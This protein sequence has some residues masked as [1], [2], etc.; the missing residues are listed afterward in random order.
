MAKRTLPTLRILV[1]APILCAWLIACQGQPAE[2]GP[3]P[4][5]PESETPPIE[6][7]PPEPVLGPAALGETCG[8][9]AGIACQDA[10]WCDPEPGL[11]GG[12]DIAGTCI[13]VPDFCT[14]DYRPVCGCDKKTYSNDC[15]RQAARVAKDHDGECT[16]TEAPAT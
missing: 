2:K 10:L 14:K 16:D 12:A 9:I 3:T 11:C 15:M 5:P 6:T 8:G 7:P 4:P 1:A 13:E